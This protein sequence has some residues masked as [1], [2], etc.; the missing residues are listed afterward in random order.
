MFYGQ[1]KKR[2][3]G[4]IEFDDLDEQQKIYL[5][6][7]EERLQN[8]LLEEEDEE[9]EECDAQEREAEAKL[10]EAKETIARQSGLIEELRGD[11]F[12]SEGKEI[13]AN[14]L[15][16]QNRRKMFELEWL[17]EDLQEE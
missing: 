6:R 15:N 13:Q 2:R 12:A 5:K 7:R 9:G 14:A 8:E 10:K 4:E 1:N 3:R 11:L 17:L 16:D